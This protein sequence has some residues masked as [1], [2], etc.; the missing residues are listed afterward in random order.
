LED[1]GHACECSFDI[2]P[3]G[4]TV[5]TGDART[6]WSD[7]DPDCYITNPPWERST[8]HALPYFLS[9]ALALLAMVCCSMRTGYSR[10]HN[11]P[12]AGAHRRCF[13]KERI[14]SAAA[15]SSDYS[16]PGEL[17]CDPFMGA[18]TTGVACALAGPS[19]ESTLK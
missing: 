19:S 14:K 10:S 5:Y 13:D 1:A 11:K 12:P 18:R 8:L 7:G 4:G 9:A 17:V 6:L 15:R 2:E 3:K 16:R